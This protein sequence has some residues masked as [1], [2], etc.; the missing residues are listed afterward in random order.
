MSK[1]RWCHTRVTFVFFSLQLLVLR[2]MFPFAN[3][4]CTQ[5]NCVIERHCGI[6]SPI[7]SSTIISHTKTGGLLFFTLLLC[8]ISFP[9]ENF[10]SNKE[11][12]AMRSHGV[13]ISNVSTV[14]KNICF[15]KYH[16]L[17]RLRANSRN[18]IV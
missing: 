13:N 2:A 4:L 5:I 3:C 9:T 6:R 15:R 11:Y 14:D 7:L 10:Q 1:Q 12:G 17:V 8:S 18:Q 16:T